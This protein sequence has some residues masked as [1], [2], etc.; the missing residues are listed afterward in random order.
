MGRRQIAFTLTSPAF[1]D[2]GTIPGRYTCDGGDHAPGLRWADPPPGTRSLV[3][4]LHDPDSTHKPDFVHWVRFDIP[5]TPGELPA[6]QA[7]AGLPGRND[8]GEAAYCGPCP[9]DGPHRCVFDLYAL[10][11]DTLGLRRGASHDEVEAAMEGHLLGRANL[12]GCC[13]PEKPL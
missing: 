8:F 11:V 12:W 13:E 4:I 7:A 10:D 9:T 1:A 2:G 3:L 6:R 5:I